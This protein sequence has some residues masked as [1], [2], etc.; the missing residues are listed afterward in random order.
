VMPEWMRQLVEPAEDD[1][2]GIARDI[3]REAQEMYGRGNDIEL[4]ATGSSRARSLPRSLVSPHRVR[5][6]EP[7]GPRADHGRVDG[8]LHG[9]RRGDDHGARDPR[10]LHGHAARELITAGSHGARSTSSPNQM[11]TL[12]SRPHVRSAAA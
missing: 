8:E 10:E 11:L 12:R 3:L 5:P 1:W 7:A 4:T 6:D 2:H 9:A